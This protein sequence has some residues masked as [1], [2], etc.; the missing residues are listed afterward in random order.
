MSEALEVLLRPSVVAAVAAAVVLWVL[1]V[2]LSRGR[3]WCLVI[4]C[5]VSLGLGEIACRALGLV[6]PER[7]IDV[8]HEE[9]IRNPE[10]TLTAICEFIGVPYDPKM[11]DYP[12]DTTYNAPDPSLVEQWRRK[13][14]EKEIRLVESR[15]AD[16][17]V[18]RG[19]ELSGLPLLEVLP[20]MARRLR[21]QD[22]WARARFRMRRYG[23]GLWAA[24]VTS[25]RIGPKRWA[26]AVQLRLNEIDR[27]HL[28]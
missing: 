27:Q 28:K 17:L 7:F 5:V 20:H 1:W 11:L 3:F 22:R 18:A 12:N 15:I 26:R 23:T 16:M 14:T 19:Y 4:S 24:S 6:A 2:R 25:R 9:L 13:A 21:R 8:K 10:R